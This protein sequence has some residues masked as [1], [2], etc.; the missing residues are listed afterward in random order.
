MSLVLLLGFGGM[1]S[2]THSAS[3][4]L[5]QQASVGYWLFVCNLLMCL[6]RLV[7]ID[8]QLWVRFLA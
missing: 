6:P 4:S 8:G 1:H 7:L 5:G 2:I 3:A